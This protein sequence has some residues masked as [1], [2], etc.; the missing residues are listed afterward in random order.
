MSE[1]GMSIKSTIKGATEGIEEDITT[2]Q[3]CDDIE[4]DPLEGARHD[5][6]VLRQT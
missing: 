3:E 2:G 1:F 5:D 6:D 4:K